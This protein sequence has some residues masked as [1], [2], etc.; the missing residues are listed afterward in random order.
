MNPSPRAMRRL[1][2]LAACIIL[3]GCGG[4]DAGSYIASARSYLAKSDF[5]AA[6]I[7]AKNALQKEP[8]NPDARYVLAE[9]LLQSGD[10]AGAE[11]EARKAI[12]LHIAPDRGYPLLARALLARGDAANVTKELGS[13]RLDTP[14]ARSELGV[15]LAS[16]YAAQDDLASAQKSLGD[17][18]AEEPRNARGLLLKAQLAAHAGDLAAAKAAVDSALE[19][20]PTDADALLMKADLAIADHR[21][22]D[23]QKLLQ[24]AVDA[25]P[26]VIA[27]RAALLSLALRTGKLDM[28][29]AQLAKMKEIEPRDLRTVYS[30]ALV[31]FSGGDFAQARDAIAPLLA[32]RPDHLPSLMLSGLVDYQL[33]SYGSAEEKLRRVVGKVPDD[34]AARRV[35]AMIELRTGRGREALDTLGPALRQFPDDP[36]LLRLAGE[37][38]L[39]LGNAPQAEA[40]Y[41]Q[42]NAL[43]KGNVASQVRLAQVRLAT[44]DTARAFSELETLA[45]Q[46]ASAGQAD[47]A[48]FSAHMKRREYDQALAVTE[49]MEK[50]MPKSGVPFN[51]RGLVY[52]AKRDLP[53]ARK[54]FEKALE[55]QPDLDAAASNLATIDVEEGNLPA[56]R[57][58]YERLI[59]KNPK[60]EHL[61]LVSAQLLALSGGPSAD[62]KARIDKAIAVNAQSVDARSALVAFDVQQGDT[63]AA[64]AAAQ[65]AIS[66]IPGNPRLLDMLATVQLMNGNADEAVDTLKQLATLQPQNAVVLVR[67]ADAQLRVKDFGSALATARRAA[68]LK[69]DLPQAWGA[70]I[71]SEFMAGKPEEAIAE[72]KKLQKDNPDKPL[73][74]ALEG[75][76]LSVQQKYLDSAAAFRTALSKQA[77]PALAVRLYITLRQAGKPDE[78]T[79]VAND[80]MKS[81]PKDVTL[82]LVLA[83]QDQQQK[84]YASAADGYKRVLDVDPDN[85]V[86]LNNLAWVLVEQGKP[87]GVEYA[88]RAHRIAPFNPNV[89]DTLGW[90]LA[91]TGQAKRGAELLKMAA[92]IAPNQADIRLHLAKALIDAG[93]R[94]AA[95]DALNRLSKL[96]KDSPIRA[97]AEKLLATL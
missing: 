1:A 24:Q 34:P 22:D 30:T 90:A 38:Y 8:E 16:A 10:A 43:D 64:L 77:T 12:E 57:D 5:N 96:D 6:I 56:A 49:A 13:R 27:P 40:A 80:W 48:L 39:T 21:V 15:L 74:Y 94:A 37:A 36:G 91:R 66:E 92:A 60:N 58:R 62:V 28:A 7:E 17:A 51:L 61:L 78:A 29:K 93:D 41:A 53:N 32:A 95:R 9:A 3:Y 79:A 54:N 11:A 2:T 82:P 69:P 26:R 44:G 73:G 84:N 19:V 14:S 63:K 52:L 68:A 45:S 46:D 72:A 76:I 33:A 89:L 87:E 81:H 55:L 50:R 85:A 25:N 35:L 70:V 20:A 97:E 71:K 18:L 4:H 31:A 47:L 65:A 67:L 83:E 88:E 42:A 75:E 59:E 23:A 86:A